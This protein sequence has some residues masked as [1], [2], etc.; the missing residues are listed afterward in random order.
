MLTSNDLIMINR[1]DE[2]ITTGVIQSEERIKK[3]KFTHPQPPNLAIAILTVTLW[4]LKLTAI[5]NNKEH[6]QKVQKMF[7]KIIDVDDCN[8]LLHIESKE[9]KYIQNELKLTFK[10]LKNIKRHSALFRREHLML[11]ADEEKLTGNKTLESYIRQ[12]IKIEE[13]IENHRKIKNITASSINNNIQSI[14]IP[15]DKT[16]YWNTIQKKIPND[17]W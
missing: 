13:Q 14:A 15:K 11:R 3:S 9:K 2:T 17:Q 1:I 4:K 7:N 8:K 16:I 12:I 5:T 10:Q 6:H